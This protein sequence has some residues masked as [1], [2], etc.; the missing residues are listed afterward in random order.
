MKWV[1][2]RVEASCA[3]GCEV[4]RK[5]WA[6]VATAKKRRGWSYGRRVVVC[7]TCADAHYN[8]RPPADTTPARDGKALAVG[9]DE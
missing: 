1:K 5:A 2:L 7:R 3:F 4:P 9:D 8:E 6:L